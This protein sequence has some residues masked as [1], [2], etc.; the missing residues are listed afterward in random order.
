MISSRGRYISGVRDITHG[1]YNHSG[2]TRVLKCECVTSYI[3]ALASVPGRTDVTL[4][5]EDQSLNWDYVCSGGIHFE[6]FQAVL[7]FGETLKRTMSP[8]V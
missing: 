2:E 8:V 3:H 7:R 5:T 4:S 6:R 1:S